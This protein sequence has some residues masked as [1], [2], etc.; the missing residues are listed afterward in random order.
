MLPI[1]K[2]NGGNK[3]TLCHHC[4]TII[5]TDHTQDLFCC[6]EHEREFTTI[7]IASEEAYPYTGYDEE[8]YCDIGAEY[9]QPAFIRGVTWEQERKKAVSIEVIAT[10]LNWVKSN[11]QFVSKGT[12]NSRAYYMCDSE[13][14]FLSLEELFEKFKTM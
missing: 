14:D 2:L 7:K 13:P 4:R 11:F 10:F 12:D 5:D 6:D 9:E 8:Y 1:H 3:A